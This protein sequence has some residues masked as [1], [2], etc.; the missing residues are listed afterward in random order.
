M[1]RAVGGAGEGCFRWNRGEE[2]WKHETQSEDMGSPV[3]GG[4][5]GLGVGGGGTASADT[6]WEVENEASIFCWRRFESR[7]EFVLNGAPCKAFRD[8]GCRT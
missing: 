7:N 4:G 8:H 3:Y 2:V 6:E 5:G 1:G